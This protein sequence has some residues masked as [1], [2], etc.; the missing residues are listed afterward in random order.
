MV[1]FLT[2]IIVALT[3]DYK[4][5]LVIISVMPILVFA[6]ILDSKFIISDLTRGQNLYANAGALA[7]EAL[8]LFKT[9]VSYGTQTREVTR[10]VSELTM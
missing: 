1:F 5:T 7:D 8:T 9:V 3:Y 10:W 4:L 6:G 2:G